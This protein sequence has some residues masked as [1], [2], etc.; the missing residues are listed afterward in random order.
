MKQGLLLP[1]WHHHANVGGMELIHVRR[2]ADAAA[3]V[4]VVYR[5]GTA[6]DPAA[7]V[8]LSHFLEHMMF[9]GSPL[10]PGTSFSQAIRD[11]GGHNNAFTTY[12]MT[13]YTSTVPLE[14]LPRLLAMEADRMRA[15][16]LEPS[17]VLKE[18]QVIHAERL[19]MLENHPMG[20]AWEASLRHLYTHHPYG[21]PPIGYPHHIEAY[22]R[23]S[24]L[25]HHRAWYGPQ[26]AT[27]LVAADMPTEELEH[28]V[29]VAFADQPMGLVRPRLRPVEPERHHG[30]TMEV[31]HPRV[32][33][34]EVSWYTRAPA[35]QVPDDGY[36]AAWNC[37]VHMISGHDASMVLEAMVREERVAL[38]MGCGV[39]FLLDPGYFH[40]SW[41]V[42]EGVEVARLEDAW[43]G[44]VRRL[45]GEDFPYEAFEQA[46]QDLLARF[47]FLLDSRTHYLSMFHRMALGATPWMIASYPDRLA[48]LTAE[49]IMEAA[50][51]LLPTEPSGRICTVPLGD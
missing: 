28:K 9:Q 37:L 17:L 6:D 33:M 50:R 39:D 31:R 14:W 12:D 30:W 45:R 24:L 47:A 3:V 32:T 22:D 38:S 2:P 29:A 7:Q 16:T 13:V 21:I 41:T 4:H 19:S 10:H 1:E 49:D 26:H 36:Y 42:A 35:W 18:Q 34:R 8:G 51:V 25:A 15:L 23:E 48:S 20:M 27:L 43:R 46:R 5:V 40:C 44:H 11:V